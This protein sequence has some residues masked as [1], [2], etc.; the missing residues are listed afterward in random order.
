MSR[1]LATFTRLCRRRAAPVLSGALALALAA[2]QQNPETATLAEQ[3][4]TP[5]VRTITSFDESLRCM[6]NMLWAQGK[7]DIYITSAGIPD[8]T[9]QVAA[10]T[11]DMLITAIS[12]MSAKS[13]A[14]RFVDYDPTQIDV[15]VLSELVG[16]RQGFI[17]P[18][19]YIRGAVTQLDSAVLSSQ[20]SAG[21]SLPVANLGVSHEQVASVVSID[22]NLGQLATRQILP[23]MSAGNSI[24]IVRAG[25][26]ADAGGV[27]G[28]AGL[29]FS[30]SFDRSEGLHQAVRNL[31]EL[32]T[33]ELV[34]KLTRVPYWQCLKADQTNP[35][36][37]TEARG[38]YDAMGAAERAR[39]VTASLAR[40]GYWSG[41]EVGAD[42]ASLRDAIARFQADNDLV[43][44]GR[45][46]FDLYY[47]LIGTNA[48]ASGA[49]GRVDA[50]AHLPEARPAPAPAAAPP[51]VVLDTSRGP[52]PTFRVD[53]DLVL[54]AQPSRD[55]FLYCY[56][57]DAAG[58]VA[59][60]FPNRFQPDA[61]V[62]AGTQID[63]PPNGSGPF[64][65]RFDRAGSREMVACLASDLELGLK[66]PETLKAK[67]LE[68]LPVGSIEAVVDRFSAA[69][70]D[71]VSVSRLPIEVVR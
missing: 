22:L 32:S 70:P 51:Q 35:T 1:M 66:L 8:A 58:T 10:G 14:F 47:R 7:K 39:F 31:I 4:Q 43:P 36:F 61:F 24:A 55:G 28:E 38:W 18:S 2:C 30:I 68:P 26:G 59:R 21:V 3:P 63:I 17:A 16:L 62:R 48:T 5:P 23:G 34:G 53:E 15:Q 11:K 54:R 40:A 33:I 41:G 49:A 64:Q 56:Y 57:Q 20:Q 6:D 29:T 46:D 65:I 45:I 50:A 37:R 42:D 67:D 19:Y 69:G 52:R 25:N 44:N 13:G 12:K 9:G 60:I 71:H 27:I